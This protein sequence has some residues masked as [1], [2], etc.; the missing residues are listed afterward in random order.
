MSVRLHPGAWQDLQDCAAFYE[1]E[2][3]PAVA[4][5]FLSEFERTARLL[6]LEPGIG[7]P[8][9]QGR[10]GFPIA[11]FPYTVIYRPEADGIAI[12]VV[13]H[14]RRRPSHGGDRR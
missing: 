13:K 14:D 4:A 11:G 1:R 6:A 12:L 3:S 2:A 8:R 5:R 9:A 7:T 10:R